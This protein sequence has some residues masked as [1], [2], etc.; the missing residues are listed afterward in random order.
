MW[1]KAR[2]NIKEGTALQTIIGNTTP[3][4]TVAIVLYLSGFLMCL[5]AMIIV[6]AR[7]DYFSFSCEYPVFWLI[8]AWCLLLLGF[9][10]EI[11][12]H[13]FF[14]RFVRILAQEEGWYLE[15]RT[16]QAGVL[17]AVCGMG[18]GVL[19]VAV[20]FLHGARWPYLLAFG[21]ILF[22][23]GYAVARL[24]S[25]HYVDVLLAQEFGG[26]TLNHF[27]ELGAT[28]CVIA[29]AWRAAPPLRFTSEIAI[30]LAPSQPAAAPAD[31][32]PAPG[33]THKNPEI[34]SYNKRKAC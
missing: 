32:T 11:N 5:R 23:I 19:G 22:L 21:G 15:R 28:L 29:A 12:L 33:T 34:G 2:V 14:T 31:I 26:I 24:V 9:T 8:A 17:I 7:M 30:P 27:V 1:S 6:R 3:G 4:G 13:T 10:R 18:L 25:F 16:L 20:W